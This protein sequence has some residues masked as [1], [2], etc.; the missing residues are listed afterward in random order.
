MFYGLESPLCYTRPLLQ[1]TYTMPHFPPPFS[2][3]SPFLP[4]SV[5]HTHASPS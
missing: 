1:K 5:N 4:T 2:P 3:F